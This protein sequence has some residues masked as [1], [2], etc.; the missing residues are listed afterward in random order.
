MVYQTLSEL[1]TDNLIKFESSDKAELGIFW[2]SED[3]SEVIHSKTVLEEDIDKNDPT[4][5]EFLHYNEWSNRPKDIPG[6]YDDYP[7]GRIFHGK[8]IYYVELN[9]P[10]SLSLESYLR[11]YFNLPTDT[12]FKTGYW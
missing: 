6:N 10:T 8:G 3:C 1:I 12:V 11:H 9:A 2:L 7:R 4:Q 5:Y